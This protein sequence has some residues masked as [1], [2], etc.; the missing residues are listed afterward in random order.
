M[1]RIVLPVT[2]TPVPSVAAIAIGVAAIRVVEV[3]P[4]AVVYEVV[5]V[6]DS[7]VVVPAPTRVVTPAAAP[8]ST[9][10]DSHAKRDRH[11][12]GIVTRRRIRDGRIGIIRRAVDN[13]WV[14]AG[15][16]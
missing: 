9:H 6:I 8:H 7:D 15:H 12:R 14:V 16:V 4:I 5:V 2:V 10:S 11:P 3:L 13:C 1:L